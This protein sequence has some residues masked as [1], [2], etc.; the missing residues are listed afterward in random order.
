MA[1]VF[2]IEVTQ[3]GHSV[4]VAIDYDKIIWSGLSWAV[5]EIKAVDLTPNEPVHV[6]F[7]SAEKDPVKL[8]GAAYLIMY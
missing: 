8:E 4:P 1:K 5:G 7:H 3:N 2:T 6:T